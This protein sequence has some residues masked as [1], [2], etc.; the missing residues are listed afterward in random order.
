MARIVSKGVVEDERRAKIGLPSRAQE[1]TTRPD[2]VA[3]KDA[4]AM[5]VT[6]LESVALRL[7]QDDHLRRAAG[8]RKFRR[9]LGGDRGEIWGEMYGKGGR[10]MTD[11]E[12]AF[13][14]GILGQITIQLVRQN[15]RIIQDGITLGY[16]LAFRDAVDVGGGDSFAPGD[17]TASGGG[18]PFRRDTER[19]R[20]VVGRE[21]RPKLRVQ[22]IRAGQADRDRAKNDMVGEYQARAVFTLIRERLMNALGSW[23]GKAE[24]EQAKPA[25]EETQLDLRL[26][27]A[28]KGQP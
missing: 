17:W 14:Q 5:L 10:E 16:D 15:N 21:G 2:L 25:V 8:E 7:G 13:L 19:K 11:R 9:N 18:L 1:M 6:G 22:F 4:D 24:A 28:P 23:D 27:G 3:Y 20:V 12:L 26:N